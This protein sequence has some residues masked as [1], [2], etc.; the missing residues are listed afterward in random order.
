MPCLK[1][2]LVLLRL[3]LEVGALIRYAASVLVWF[4]FHLRAL[5]AS[6]LLATPMVLGAATHKCWCCEEKP[7]LT[8]AWD[9]R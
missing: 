8:R 5:V 9:H 4:L 3:L 1:M 2:L 6:L 7:P